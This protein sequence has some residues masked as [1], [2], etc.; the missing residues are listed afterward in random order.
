M[1]D[2]GFAAHLLPSSRA[3]SLLITAGYLETGSLLCKA[4]PARAWARVS[5]IVIGAKI[6]YSS[7]LKDV[8]SDTFSDFISHLY[9]TYR[10]YTHIERYP[11]SGEYFFIYL[12]WD[13]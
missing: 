2:L 8:D 11:R 7:L 13:L 9:F 4:C 6:L 10:L 5:T 12:I 1:L 3:S